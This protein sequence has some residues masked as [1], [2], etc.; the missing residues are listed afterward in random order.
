[1]YLGTPNAVVANTDSD[2]FSFFRPTD[3]I[4]HVDEVNFWRPGSQQGFHALSP[5]EPFFFRLK[6]PV[7]A[8]AGF[9]FFAVQSFMSVSTAW[10][11]FESKNGVEHQ[12]AFLERLA[13]YRSIRRDEAWTLGT[14]QLN[15]LILR[16][17]VFLPESMWVEWRQESE[18]APNIV[19]FKTYDL[20]S[21]VGQ[22]LEEILRMAPTRGVPD[23]A[24]RF[25]PM[26]ADEREYG[27][28]SAALRTG[29]GTFRARL[30]NAYQGRCAITQEKSVPVL[31]AAHI[32][33]YL[34]P[35]SNHVQNGLLLRV[36][37]HR[38]YDLGYVTVTP[39]YQ[40]DVSSRLKDE[41]NNG[42]HY[43]RYQGLELNVP[44]DPKFKPSREALDWHS[45]EI[46]R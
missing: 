9:G 16:E 42:E 26:I 6:H 27:E 21:K 31:D 33:P 19:A 12:Q 23:L 24:P 41:F 37:L 36:D 11:W 3:Q 34:G 22:R 40:I 20:T 15:C 25:S 2:W 7:N 1:V 4:T 43:Y 30:L 29:Q 35:G 38:L 18:W 32:Q 13:H 17:A 39:D 46:F 28:Y 8:V 45:S 44:D 10:R 5:G 14:Q